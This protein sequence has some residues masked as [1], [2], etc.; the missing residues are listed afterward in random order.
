LKSKKELFQLLALTVAVLLLSFSVL[1]GCGIGKPIDIAK[2]PTNPK[3][4]GQ[5]SKNNTYDTAASDALEKEIARLNGVSGASVVLSADTAWVAVDLDRAAG[6]LPEGNSPGTAVPP[7]AAVTPG[8]TNP[9]A[10]VTPPAA[11][12]TT[13]PQADGVAKGT[14]TGT[15]STTMGTTPAGEGSA[16]SQELRE[17]IIRLVKDKAPGVDT[18]YI[19]AGDQNAADIRAIRNDLHNG[20]GAVD[21]IWEDLKDIGR[22]ITGIS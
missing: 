4:P 19:A 22:R 5:I 13:K 10:T 8:E 21:S 9:P 15:G 20:G 17:E 2:D 3:A 1:A 18:V 12:P 14:G 7:G 16:L 11:P 6:D